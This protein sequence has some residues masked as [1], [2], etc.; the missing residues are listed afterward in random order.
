MFGN[1]MG[2]DLFF[3][4]IPLPVIPLPINRLC[5]FLSR[6]CC[7]FI[8]LADAFAAALARERN[9]DLVTGAPEFKP[10][11]KEIKIHWLE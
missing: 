8:G 11:Q 2:K 9:T 1:G 7:I 5:S 10:L 3:V 4:F 6:R